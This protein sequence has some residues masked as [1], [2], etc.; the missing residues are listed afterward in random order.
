M[1]ALVER[2]TAHE[3]GGEDVVILWLDSLKMFWSRSN[4]YQDLPDDVQIF[5]KSRRTV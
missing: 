1:V 3:H 2:L 5:H 4:F